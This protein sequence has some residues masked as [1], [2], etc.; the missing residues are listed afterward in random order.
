M[1][2]WRFA[3]IVQGE[4]EISG[5]LKTIS[6]SPIISG[7]SLMVMNFIR[8]IKIAAYRILMPTSDR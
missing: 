6:P 5:E 4:C 8:M 3:K 2:G 1:G 7:T